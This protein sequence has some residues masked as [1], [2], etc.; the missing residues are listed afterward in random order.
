VLSEFDT[1]TFIFIFKSLMCQEQG[2]DHFLL[3]RFGC[4]SV[5]FR[6]KHP[7]PEADPKGD[8]KETRTPPPLIPVRHL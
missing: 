3:M 6:K 5:I 8:P 1:N 4:F 2:N 7:F